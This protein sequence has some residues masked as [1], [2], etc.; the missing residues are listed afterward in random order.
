MF[1]YCFKITS[2]FVRFL[3]I[4]FTFL[5]IQS[6]IAQN[7]SFI[8]DHYR[9][10]SSDEMSK[11]QIVIKPG[12]TLYNTKGEKL[13]MSQ[14]SLM[15]NSEY[16]PQFFV[17]ANTDIKAIVFNNKSETNTI[18]ERSTLEETAFTKGKRAL[19]FIAQDSDGNSIKLSELRGNV[20][21]LN[22]WFIK[23]GP[24]VA[25]MPA[26]NAMKEQYKDQDVKF[27]AITFDK[28]EMIEQFLERKDFNYDMIPDASHVI[29]M[30]GV[31]S[32]PTNIIIDKNGYVALK[33]TGFRTNIQEVLSA[34]INKSLK[35]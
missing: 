11:I 29:Q 20:V 25:E 35:L 26:L 5:S 10:L 34:S 22:F 16:Y 21:V 27:L 23:C 4:A 15:T 14:L 19:D 8:P 2:M 13:P 18:I 6:T 9:L 3:L 12:I 30:Y 28:Q 1:N 31:Q 32:F 17:D 7:Y 24:C 33:E